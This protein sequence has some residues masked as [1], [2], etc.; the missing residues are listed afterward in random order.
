M[1]VDREASYLRAKQAK[2]PGTAMSPSPAHHATHIKLLTHADS[3]LLKSRNAVWHPA[4]PCA[5]HRLCLT[6]VVQAGM[7]FAD[8]GAGQGCRT[9]RKLSCE[10]GVLNCM[11]LMYA[12]VSSCSGALPLS[13]WS[14]LKER[15][16]SYWLPQCPLRFWGRAGGWGLRQCQRWP[17][18]A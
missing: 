9:R 10:L 4:H 6:N 12:V 8:K 2:S 16:G 14:H 7:R 17:Q 3:P 1:L 5:L 15:R 13:A 11:M 18:S